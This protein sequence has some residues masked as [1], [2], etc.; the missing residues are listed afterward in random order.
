MD[1]AIVIEFS[2]YS[3]DKIS[4]NII[5]YIY[6]V[7][8]GRIKSAATTISRHDTHCE[9][10]INFLALRGHAFRWPRGR[11]GHMPTSE[12]S[13]RKYNILCRQLHG[14]HIF[15]YIYIYI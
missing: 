7:M 9:C 6:V 13:H 4:A 8:H 2:T 5:L 11:P 12:L 14:H 15:I 3:I 1:L 10:Y